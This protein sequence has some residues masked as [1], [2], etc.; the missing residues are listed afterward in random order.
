M[1]LLSIVSTTEEILD[2]K[3][4]AP[5]YET[6]NMALGIRH[7]DHV[8]ASIRKSLQLLRRQAAVVGR[9]CSLSDSDHGVCFVFGNTLRFV[10]RN[11]DHVNL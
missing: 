9:Y 2:R 5:V 1:G 7:A 10:W 3:A 6:E 4:A 8:A 11:W